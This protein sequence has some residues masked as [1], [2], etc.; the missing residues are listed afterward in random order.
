MDW[1]RMLLVNL[2]P[3]PM[4]HKKRMQADQPSATRFV[5]R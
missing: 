2:T 1:L 5:D 4:P 3:D